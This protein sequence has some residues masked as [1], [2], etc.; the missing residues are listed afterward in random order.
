MMNKKEKPWDSFVLFA[1]EKMME[2][3]TED[4]FF[5][6]SDEYITL[7]KDK[8]NDKPPEIVKCVVTRREGVPN[9]IAVYDDML[10]AMESE[11]ASAESVQSWH[12]TWFRHVKPTRS[13]RS[14]RSITAAVATLGSLN[15]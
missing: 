1:P 6:G 3:D 2:Q 10:F 11:T 13:S 14:V 5:Y 15:W 4:Y 8:L 7:S 12:R 9:Q